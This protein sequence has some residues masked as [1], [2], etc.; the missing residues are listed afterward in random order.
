MTCGIKKPNT[1]LR[2][3]VGV[4]II[5][6]GFYFESY[7]GALGTIPIIFAIIGFCPICY[8]QAI[9]NKN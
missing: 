5:A 2:I 7:F 4:F 8:L 9:K 1:L 3:F 6:I